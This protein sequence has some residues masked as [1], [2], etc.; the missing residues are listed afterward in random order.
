LVIYLIDQVAGLNRSFARRFA[1]HDSTSEPQPGRRQVAVALAP[2]RR[3]AQHDPKR[4]L[5]AGGPLV[6]FSR[7]EAFQIDR[8]AERRGVDPDEE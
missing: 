1:D 2:E 5:S 4:N 3:A 7:C 6:G 8:F